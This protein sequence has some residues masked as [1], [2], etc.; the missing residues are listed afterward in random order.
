MINKNKLG[1]F[2]IIR[3]LDLIAF[4][5]LFVGAGLVRYGNDEIVA[6]LGGFVMAGAATILSLA[7]YAS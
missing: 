4:V 3:A 5:L 1:K 7:R 6:I 2:D